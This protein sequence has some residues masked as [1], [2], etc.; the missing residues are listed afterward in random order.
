LEPNS[1]IADSQASIQSR[2]FTQKPARTLCSQQQ[3]HHTR[4]S[5]EFPER[6][7]HILFSGQKGKCTQIP[8]VTDLLPIKVSR[9]TFEDLSQ[10][11]LCQ[12]FGI[13]S[14]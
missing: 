10:G 12:E 14:T 11:N 4:K 7:V 3:S 2:S 1:I 8:D 6:H 5:L 13:S 9:Q